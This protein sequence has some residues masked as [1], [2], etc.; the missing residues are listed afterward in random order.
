MED[1]DERGARLHC[2]RSL[3]TWKGSDGS[4]NLSLRNT[5]E[6]GAEI[7]AALAP[8]HEAIF[9]GPA[10]PDTTSRARPTPPTP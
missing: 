2:Q 10:W 6:A 4:W 9:Q 3:R 1:P 7:E 8:L 5:P